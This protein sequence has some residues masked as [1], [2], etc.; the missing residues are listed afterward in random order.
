MNVPFL[1]KFRSAV[2][3]TSVEETSSYD[4]SSQSNFSEG[5]TLAWQVTKRSTG[6]W[7]SGHTVKGHY[8]RGRWVSSHWV[9]GKHDSKVGH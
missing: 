8:A 1:F 4:V 7:T 9:G 6:C 5:V 3:Q 2:Y